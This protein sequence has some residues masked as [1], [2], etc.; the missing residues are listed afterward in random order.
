MPSSRP[1][2]VLGLCTSLLLATGCATRSAD[3]RPVAADASMFETWSCEAIDDERDRVQQRAADVAYAVDARVGNN[4]IA[5]SVAVTVFW[6][7][8]IAMRPDGPE[9]EELG[10]LRGRFD[11]LQAA[12]ERRGCPPPSDA[13]SPA[14]VAA[15]PV[16]PGERLVYEERPRRG[17]AQE[18]GLR[19]TALR[20]GVVDFQADVPGRPQ[21]VF[22]QQDAAGN[23][24]P[25]TGD[26]GLV[27]WTRFLKRDMGLGDVLSGNVVGNGVS[28]RLRG[29]VI[30]VGVQTRF[31]R[32]FD[33]AV[34]ELF[35]DVPYRD[36]SSRLDGVMVVD[37]KSG[38]LLRLEL[39]STHPD[40]SLRRTLLRI[41]TPP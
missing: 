25:A 22:W 1:A 16:A 14:K 26:T 17:P 18:L 23:L 39:R 38:V 10:R 9:A 29:Q 7:A 4:V 3:V 33:A 11:A 2:T 41:E 21:P 30:A 8:L 32:A 13:L 27:H 19:I 31:G 34:V 12:A 37:R 6:P 28:G 35:G 5:L 15:L 24:A 40:F 36:T 20:R